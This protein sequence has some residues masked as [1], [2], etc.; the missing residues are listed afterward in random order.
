MDGRHDDSSRA[1]SCWTS[2]RGR[3]IQ[4]ASFS[5]SAKIA[6]PIPDVET[7]SV[8]SDLISAVR[9]PLA[10]VA[11]IAW[12]IQSACFPRLNEYRSAIPNDAIIAIGLATPFPAMSGAEPCTGSYNALRFLVLGSTSPSDAD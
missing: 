11:E 9:S 2:D 8:P 1:F 3:K 7:T 6:E 4:T 10:S 5:S 12:S